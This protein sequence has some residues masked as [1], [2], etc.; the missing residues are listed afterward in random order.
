VN[1]RAEDR[2]NFTKRREIS[3]SFISMDAIAE[4]VITR[5]FHLLNLWNITTEETAVI[6]QRLSISN[7]KIKSW[8]NDRKTKT[9]NFTFSNN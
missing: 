7:A 6:A 4:G 8:L 3:S 5:Y 1:I 9:I 2:N